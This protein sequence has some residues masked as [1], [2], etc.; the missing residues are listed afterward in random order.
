[1]ILNGTRQRAGFYKE[2]PETRLPNNKYTRDKGLK[3]L[4]TISATFSGSTI[5]DAA[6]LF[7]TDGGFAVDD[8]IIIWNSAL[9]NGVRKI[10]S[11]T[12]TEL[13]VDWPVKTEGPTAGVV[14]RMT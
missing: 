5:T 10:L 3:K 6:I 9:N 1:M 7:I 8:Q 4:L 11:L 13:T 12:E 2:R 14:V